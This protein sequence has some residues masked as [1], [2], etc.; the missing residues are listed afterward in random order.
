MQT[1]RPRTARKGRGRRNTQAFKL[2]LK[3]APHSN[4]L[5]PSASQGIKDHS[6][7]SG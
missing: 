3:E 5:P 7:R 4:A 2:A 6:L 1:Y